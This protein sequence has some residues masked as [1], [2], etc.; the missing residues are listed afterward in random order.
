MNN[1][2][3]S[4]SAGGS[5]G[6]GFGTG[7]GFVS[8]GGSAGGAAGGRAGGSAGGSTAGGSAGGSTAGGSAGGSTAGGSAGGSTAGG[9]AG[10]D[11]GGSAGG[12]MAGGSAG[13]EAG[14]SAGGS[15]AGGSAGG[16]AGGSAGGSTAGGSAG[17]STL[18][19]EDCANAQ[20]LTGPNAVVTGD[21]TGAVNDIRYQSSTVCV[22]AFN[23]TGGDVVYSMVVPSFNRVAATLRS[24]LLDGGS[25]WDSTF[26][27]VVGTATACGSAL[28]DGG[29]G[30]Q[31]CVAGV[32]DPDDPTAA[33]QFV[34]TTAG[35]QTVFFVVDGYDPADFGP[36]TLTADV[37]TVPAGDVCEN[38]ETLTLP[39]SRAAD[40]LVAYANNY[41]AGAGCASGSTSV[42]RTYRVNVPA[43]NRLTAVVTA[44]TNSDGGVAFAPTVNVVSAATCATPLSCAAGGNSTNTPGLATAIFDNVGAARDVFVVV[45]TST[46]APGGTYSLVISAAPVTLPAGD[47]CSNVGAPITAT[48]SFQN[49]TFS[50]FGDQYQSQGQT[51]CSYLPGLDRVYAVT[52]PAGQIMTA[53][54]YAS[55]AGVLPDGGTINLA[56][57]VVPAANNCQTG[58]CALSSNSTSVAGATETVVRSNSAGATSENVLL[59]VDSNLPAAAGSF[60]LNVNLAAPSVGDTCS[61]TQPA[62]MASISLGMEDLAGYA[63]DYSAF[64]SGCEFASGVDRT[65]R[66]TIPAG[67]ALTATT[68]T[69][70]DHALSLV[71]GPAANCAA[72]TSCL[73][74]ADA[75]FTGG[76]ETLTYSN[77]SSTPL[78]VFLVVDRFGSTTGTTPYGL[79]ID[80]AAIPMSPY[81]KSTIAQACSTLASPTPLITTI[82]DD[83]TSPITALPLAFSFFG[84]PVTHFAATTNGNVQFFTAAT[85]TVSGQWTNASIPA[86]SVPNG[87]AAPFWDDLHIPS[88]G[89]APAI[90]YEVSGTAPNQVLTVEWFDISI[91]TGGAGG[92][93][94]R[95]ELLNFQLKLFE[96]TNVVE[97]HY[98]SLV[99]GTGTANAV[100]GSGA[101]VGLENLMGTTGVQHSFNTASSVNT[102]D[103]YRFTP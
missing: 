2:P 49:D 65:Y 31:A 57:S 76:G 100:S 94:T 3:D 21:T 4:G 16:E 89:G 13:G 74:S 8:A 7:G 79:T 75:V 48:T 19:N 72:P 37:T 11:A 1:R 22:N 51:S 43:N 95:T 28:T 85:G 86:V 15:M 90:R 61:D 14:G 58:P 44:S 10:G 47:V 33:Q 36:F 24:S 32:D 83:S 52:I 18:A 77:A 27:L 23:P 50:G 91:A 98:C 87:F 53:T 66:I 41:T 93:G 54:A 96:T 30:G 84:T 88:A 60:A 67:F 17:G 20:V 102:T 35:N 46:T 81:V 63:N 5:A 80:L 92:T 9:S 45:D 39:A 69:T 42:D 59:V 38:A 103:A 6:G 101:T 70:A 99:P 62:I 26:N 29:F 71:N 73:A 64:V 12:S 78:S 34:N 55:D 56:L 97:F 82:G 68:T 25:N 40:T